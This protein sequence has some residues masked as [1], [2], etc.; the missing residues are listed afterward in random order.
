LCGLFIRFVGDG[1]YRFDSC[2]KHVGSIR[3][4][5][6]TFTVGLTVKVSIKVTP[7]LTL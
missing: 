3:W 7:W 5:F 4:G 2:Y 1:L 6:V